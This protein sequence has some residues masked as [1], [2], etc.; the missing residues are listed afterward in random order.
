MSDE[1]DIRTLLA[2]LKRRRIS[3]E[4][5]R[6]EYQEIR[7]DILSDLS[8]GELVELGP[9]V[10]GATPTPTPAN[11]LNI[12][13]SGGVG[14]GMKTRLDQ[15]A[16]LTIEPG[17][18]LL[19]QF[20]VVRE[21]GRG[22]FGAVFEAVDLHLGD[23]YA[24][25]VLDPKMVENPDLLARFRR[26]VRLMRGLVHPHIV[27]VHDY[28]EDEQQILALISMEL[29]KGDSVR[30]LM[31]LARGAGGSVRPGLVQKVLEQALE[32][33]A[34]A[35]AQG[36]IHRDV[37]PANLLLGGG[38]AS[39]LLGNPDVDPHVKLVDFGIAGLV[40]RSELSQKSRSM[41]TVTY[42][43]PELHD[44]SSEITPAVD[45]YSLGAVA[46]EML[47]GKA[48]LVT[49]HRPVAEL[50]PGAVGN[51]AKAVDA[52]VQVEPV[53]RPDAARSL[54][55]LRRS[56]VEVIAPKLG[57]LW[58]DPVLGIRFRLIPPGTFM[59]GSPEDEPER[60]EDETRHE[61]T[62]ARGIWVAE[63]AVTQGQY[64]ALTGENPS[65]FTG[66]DDLPV[67]NVSWFDAVRCADL[68]SERA[69]LESCYEV[70]SGEEPDVRLLGLGR[71][72]F[73]LPTEAEWEYFCRAGTTTPFWTGNNLT[74][75]Q[76]NYDG[77]Y[78]YEGNREGIKR[79][80]TVPVRSFATNPWGLYE[81]HGNVWEWVWDWWGDDHSG[82][83][84][85]PIGPSEGSY[86]VLRGGSWY[87]GARYCRSA[88]R[89]WSLPGYRR[90]NLGL[91]LV[92]TAG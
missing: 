29:V 7:E 91:R 37:S 15:Q 43:A 68:L 88:S 3:G 24:V 54:D 89:S 42:L 75:D 10:G 58:E 39:Q 69:G 32:A 12:G 61:V 38:N 83:V 14:G 35:H 13:P 11:P 9:A 84:T 44:Q 5:T 21:L 81:V 74:T 52:M 72:G 46:Y 82:S 76:A 85:D 62:L 87:Y 18:V 30:G 22:G 17:T 47:T 71:V 90:V 51:L 86:R 49:G 16:S 26:E 53:R 66:C 4:I 8:P 60:S 20:R 80:K 64:K 23:T 1:T 79:G 34:E 57:D 78:P 77:N 2:Q 92:R 27:R 56:T 36:I 19:D 40:E 6:E 50:A 73:R 48:P 59:M 41:G 70:G 33:L 55:Q 63:T 67:E 65:D 45:I 25:K 28:R 31:D